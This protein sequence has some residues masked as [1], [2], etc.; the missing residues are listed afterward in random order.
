MRHLLAILA[1]CALAGC[2]ARQ[3]NPGAAVPIITGVPRGEMEHAAGHADCNCV[4][5]LFSAT[6]ERATIR[7]HGFVDPPALALVHEYQHLIEASL[8]GN[9]AALRAVRHC[10]RSLMAPGFEYGHADLM[11]ELP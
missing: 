8:R 7:V 9:H 10:F 11:T 5:G 2:G 6:P 1:L 4:D 3:I